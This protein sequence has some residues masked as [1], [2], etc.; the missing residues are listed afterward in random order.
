MSRTYR[1][2]SFFPSPPATLHMLAV[3]PLLLASYLSIHIIL[4][5]HPQV[6]TIFSSA[7]PYS[8]QTVSSTHVHLHGSSD[9]NLQSPPWSHEWRAKAED[10]LKT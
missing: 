3:A 8:V 2:L 5:A 6:C 10:T 1:Y 7:S 4:L 9:D